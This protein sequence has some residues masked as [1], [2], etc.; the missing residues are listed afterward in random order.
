MNPSDW[1]MLV[2]LTGCAVVVV[3][4]FVSAA[5][6][7]WEGDDQGA[8]SLL[9]CWFWPFLI[10]MIPQYVYLLARSRSFRYANDRWLR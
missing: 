5:R 1:F 10:I 6:G 8:L 9:V 2:Y 7:N 3:S 4:S